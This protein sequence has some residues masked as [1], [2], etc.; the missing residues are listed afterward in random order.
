MSKDEEFDMDD[1]IKRISRKTNI[2]V[3]KSEFSFENRIKKL[4]NEID[5]IMDKKIK[6]FDD[7]KKLTSD[8]LTTGYTQDTINRYREKLKRI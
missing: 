6:E 1:E 3:K 2:N 7:N 4:D 5:K 8:Y